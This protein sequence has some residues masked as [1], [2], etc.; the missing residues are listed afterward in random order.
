[1]RLPVSGWLEATAGEARRRPAP[2][3][4]HASASSSVVES[5]VEREMCCSSIIS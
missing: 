1:M 4:P 2:R 3:R 5:S